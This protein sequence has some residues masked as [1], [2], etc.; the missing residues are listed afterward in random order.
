MDSDHK[1]SINASTRR[2][3]SG[4]RTDL[5]ELVDVDKQTEWASLCQSM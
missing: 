2:I 5:A 4:G 3:D 1:C